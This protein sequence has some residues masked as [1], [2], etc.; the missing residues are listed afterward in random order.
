M[1]VAAISIFYT[2]ETKPALHTNQQTSHIPY[3]WVRFSQKRT[4]PRVNGSK[5][6]DRLTAA[7]SLRNI[8]NRK[9]AW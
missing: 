9:N 7:Q 6:R 3:R 4:E 1:T 8:N 5:L 2:A